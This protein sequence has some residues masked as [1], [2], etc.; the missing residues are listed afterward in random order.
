VAGTLASLELVY[1]AG[2][3][4]IDDTGA[5]MISWRTT[6]DFA[7]PQFDKPQAP[8]YTTVTASNG[9]ELEYR[10]D[11]MNIRPLAHTLFIRVKKDYLREGDRITVRL[12]DRSAGSPGIRLQTNCEDAFTLHVFVDAF[13]TFDF[14]PLPV[15]P[16][17]RLVAGPAVKWKA[18][19]PTLRRAGTPGSPFRL[20]ITAEDRWGNPAQAAAQ[21]LVLSPSAPVQGLPARVR[22]EQLPLVI[23][24]LTAAGEG[25]VTVDVKDANGVLLTRSNPLVSDA[26]T[27]LEAYWGDLHGQSGETIG[28]NTARSYF[29]FARDQ[30]FIDVVGHQG[31]DFQITQ[32]FWAELKSL[33]KEFHAPGTFIT[34]PGYEWS[35]NT[36]LG[37]D[38]NVLLPTEEGTMHR[39]SHVLVPNRSDADTDCH[40]AAELLA[41]LRREGALTCAHVGGRYADVTVAHDGVVERA[42]EV[43]STWGTFEWILHDALSKGYRVGVVCNSDDHK[44]R[45]GATYPGASHFGAIGGLT[46]LLLPKLT[47]E[48]VYDALRRRHTYGTTG[49]RLHLDVRARFERDAEVFDDDP[50]L[51]PAASHSARTAMMGDVVRP[52]TG[53]GN[54]STGGHPRFAASGTISGGGAGGVSLEVNVVG[55]A[56]LERI[57][58]F[59][60]SEAVHVERLHRPVGRRV[61]LLWEGAE[62]RG[63][64]RE[65]KWDGQATLTGTRYRRA[66]AVNFLNPDRVLQTAPDGQHVA[67]RS[68]T[69]GNFNGVDLWLEDPR[70]PRNGE[71]AIATPVVNATLRLAELGDEDWVVHAGGLGRQLRAFRLSDEGGPMAH[72]FAVPISLKTQGDTAV[73]VRVTQEDGH[74]AWSSPIYLIH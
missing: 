58:V 1:T 52:Y 14:A 56:P 16:S 7:K 45:P 64:G 50:A 42:V 66:Q 57:T 20:C 63:R 34:L 37:G 35:G 9:A 2:Y 51:G 40:S 33:N 13:A 60:G 26:A 15:S 19:L 59:V 41:T 4:G 55:S 61:R 54:A 71:I 22:M 74:Q 43:H 73:Y 38:R 53:G 72:R 49:T 70:N 68:I 17:I 23:E 36:G 62:C 21:E 67:W 10:V 28:A 29:T 3:F 48:A 39:S 18:V 27:P 46:C 69:T 65:T 5:I 32:E 24:G 25:R 8:N 44:G 31:N 11:R 47:R 12:G 6:S 30:A